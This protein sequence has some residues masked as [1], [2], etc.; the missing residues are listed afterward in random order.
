MRIDHEGAEFPYRQLA[1][2]LRAAIKS[3]RP[4]GAASPPSG[5]SCGTPAWAG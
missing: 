2:L 4:P 1:N 5:H 3:G